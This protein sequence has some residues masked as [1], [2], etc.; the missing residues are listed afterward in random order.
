MAPTRQTGPFVAWSAGLLAG[1]GAGI[2]AALASVFAGALMRASL[3]PA[4]PAAGSAFVA[5]LLGGLLYAWL[6]RI[7]S[8]PRLVFWIVAL[9]LATIDSMNSGSTVRML[10]GA[11]AGAGP[12]IF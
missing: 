6:C 7:V 2:A 11:C 4:V 9:S 1:A 8:R 5:G 10:L 12:A 3:P